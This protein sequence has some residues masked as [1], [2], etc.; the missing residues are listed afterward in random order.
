MRGVAQH[1]L[2]IIDINNVNIGP[3]APLHQHLALCAIA[4]AK[5]IKTALWEI[6]DKKAPSANK[7]SAY[8]CKK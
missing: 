8:L 4:N 5:Q 7:Y 1:E 3:K 6:G 2:L